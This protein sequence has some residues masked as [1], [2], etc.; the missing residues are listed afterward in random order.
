MYDLRERGSEGET[1]SVE[2][3]NCAQEVLYERRI[4]VQ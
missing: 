2:K 4:N 1:R 3:G